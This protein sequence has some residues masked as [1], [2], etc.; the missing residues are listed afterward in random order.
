MSIKFSTDFKAGTSVNII[1]YRKYKYYTDCLE[2]WG[3]KSGIIFNTE[4]IMAMDWE[5]NGKNVF[6][7]LTT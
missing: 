1:E 4:K 3:S 5:T 2:Y 7:Q 6:Y